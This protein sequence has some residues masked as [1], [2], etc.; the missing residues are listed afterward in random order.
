MG[1]GLGLFITKS[2]VESHGGKIWGYNNKD[3]VGATFA[4]TL[5]KQMQMLSI[6]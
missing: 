1:T 4:F 2:L 5:P 6:R 3:G